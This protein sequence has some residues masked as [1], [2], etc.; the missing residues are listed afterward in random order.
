MAFYI[1]LTQLVKKMLGS[2]FLQLNLSEKILLDHLTQII[3]NFL[4]RFHNENF[5]L[6]YLSN[7]YWN[8][9]KAKGDFA[10]LTADF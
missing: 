2:V 5:L 3:L 1:H 4:I 10:P 9:L 6:W 8:G 7:S